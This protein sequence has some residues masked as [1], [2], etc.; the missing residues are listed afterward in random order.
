MAGTG[1]PPWTLPSARKDSWLPGRRPRGTSLSCGEPERPLRAASERLCERSAGD[2]L[3]LRLLLRLRRPE[4][5]FFPRL[6]LRLL[7]SLRLL[8][9]LLDLLRLFLLLD[10]CLWCFFSFLC[11]F[12]FFSFAPT[13]AS[14]SGRM[15]IS[16]SSMLL[17]SSARGAMPSFHLLC[18]GWFSS[19]AHPD[20]ASPHLA[21][22]SPSI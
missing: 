5:R 14:L 19:A 18:A 1:S 2:L 7:L 4:W 12:S 17:L 10:L 20:S 9:L 15:G 21:H 16:P 22:L 6:R 3:R 13:S 11:F 8:D